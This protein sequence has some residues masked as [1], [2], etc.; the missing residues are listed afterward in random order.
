VVGKTYWMCGKERDIFAQ[1][2]TPDNTRKKPDTSLRN[3]GGPEDQVVVNRLVHL[4]AGITDTAEK[5]LLLAQALRLRGLLF[6]GRHVASIAASY[7]SGGG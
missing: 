4:L 7:G 1:Y 6:V 2:T 5:R 3:Y